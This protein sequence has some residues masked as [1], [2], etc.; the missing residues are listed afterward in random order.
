VHIVGYRATELIAEPALGL[1]LEALAGDFAW[2]LRGHPTLSE[3]LVE[4]GRA[5]SH[6]ALYIPKW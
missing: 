6:Q 3:S 4:A 1:Q 5:F 2:A